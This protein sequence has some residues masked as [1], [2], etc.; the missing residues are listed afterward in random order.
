MGKGGAGKQ[1]VQVKKKRVATINYNA[2]R[3][4]AVHLISVSAAANQ[5]PLLSAG[6]ASARS[7]AARDF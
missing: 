5:P 4:S 2:S 6:D 1:H 7:A 3:I